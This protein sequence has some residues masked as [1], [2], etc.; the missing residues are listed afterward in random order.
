MVE[1]TEENSESEAR[2]EQLEKHFVRV[3][4]FQAALAV[5]GILT[6][7]V[8]LWAAIGEADAVRKQQAASVY[9]ELQFA[10]SFTTDDTG[11]VFRFLMV[12]NGI[13]PG[14]VKAFRF[15]F[16]GT[17]LQSWRGLVSQISDE[18]EQRPEFTYS[19]MTGRLIRPGETIVAFETRDSATIDYL[20]VN[21]E[22]NEVAY[23][24]CSIFDDCWTPSDMQNEAPISQKQCT[25]YGPD[26]F[27]Q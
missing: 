1:E 22:M 13:G 21:L 20:M 14:R 15:T 23:C 7:L 5:A 8:A 27:L 17:P 11:K 24:Y 3:S 6:G 12:N 18:D 19:Q 26:G 25:S 10:H 9:P 2:L 16:D 4:F